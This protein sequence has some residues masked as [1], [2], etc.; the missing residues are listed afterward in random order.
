MTKLLEEIMK[1][2]KEEQMDIA[3]AIYLH[4][5]EDFPPHSLESHE[6]KE[7]LRKKLESQSK[8]PNN[9]SSWD[10]MQGRIQNRL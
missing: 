1:L 5:A 3:D 4:A 8:T 6:E 10:E 2:S 7:W 9:M